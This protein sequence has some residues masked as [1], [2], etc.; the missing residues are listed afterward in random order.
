[1]SK[2]ALLIQSY[3]QGRSLSVANFPSALQGGGASGSN[4]G[5]S[6][7]DPGSGGAIW[8]EPPRRPLGRP[9]QDTSRLSESFCESKVDKSRLHINKINH[10]KNCNFHLPQ[11]LE[12]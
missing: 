10:L 1:M 9:W 7:N 4:S 6:T 3:S 12:G 8:V 5:K 2:L 11:L